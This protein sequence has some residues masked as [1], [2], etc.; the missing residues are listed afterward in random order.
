MR[1][2]LLLACLLA[3]GCGT[4]PST[5]I[6]VRIANIGSGLQT[7]CVPVT[8]ASTLGFYKEAG[9]DVT[10][11]NL[12]STAKTLEALMGGSADAAVIH[13]QQAMQM[14]VEGKDWRFDALRH[15]R[16]APARTLRGGAIRKRPYEKRQAG[17]SRPPKTLGE[18]LLLH[19]LRGRRQDA[20]RFVPSAK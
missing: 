12:P 14:A 3:A 7:F 20:R 10:L 8:L 13:M 16:R 4:K 5:A 1:H 11:I 19:R 2:W 9:L 6:S 17:A 15:G 18:R